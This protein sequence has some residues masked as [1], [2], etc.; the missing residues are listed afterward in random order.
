MSS[1]MTPSA[2]AGPSSSSVSSAAKKMGASKR[3]ATVPMK[4]LGCGSAA[5]GQDDTVAGAMVIE[6]PAAVK[7]ET[8][9]LG[10]SSGPKPAEVP[11]PKERTQCSE[12]VDGVYSGDNAGGLSGSGVGDLALGRPWPPMRIRVKWKTGAD[13]DAVGKPGGPWS[14]GARSVVVGA[15][16][17]M[18]QVTVE[19]RCQGRLGPRRMDSS[20]ART[21]KGAHPCIGQKLMLCSG[22]M[23]SPAAATELGPAPSSP[24]RQGT[25]RGPQRALSEWKH[26]PR[27]RT[28][29]SWCTRRGWRCARWRG[30]RF[31]RW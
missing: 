28:P 8:R 4:K 9:A 17:E 27:C 31:Q 11:L 25:W 7:E 3:T 2:G 24:W 26:L 19:A 21:V 1:S 14:S 13:V 30:W 29:W 22:S 20:A 15:A 5:S 10:P 16:V 12:G 23:T 6:V 18:T